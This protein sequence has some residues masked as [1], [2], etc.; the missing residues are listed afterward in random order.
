[1]ENSANTPT[2]PG[3]PQV[4]GGQSTFR[5]R[6]YPPTQGISRPR[7]R[8]E[9]KPSPAGAPG[10]LPSGWTAR[11]NRFDPSRG[12]LLP[13]SRAEPNSQ[14]VDP[15]GHHLL[16]DATVSAD[17]EHVVSVKLKLRVNPLL[18]SPCHVRIHWDGENLGHAWFL[19]ASVGPLHQHHARHAV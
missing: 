3:I 18:R 6:G 7:D 12:H 1:D 13:A 2:V 10:R 4:A 17:V 16:H 8:L 9:A 14:V 15:R 5:S 19:A 11:S